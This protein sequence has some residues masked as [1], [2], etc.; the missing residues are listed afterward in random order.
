MKQCLIFVLLVLSLLLTSC[1]SKQDAERALKAAGFSNIHTDGFA[2]F[3]CGR[4]DFYRTKFSATNPKGDKVYGVV[5]S[6]LFF[7]NATIRF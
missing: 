5:C 2:W 6:G 1:T 4:D 3:A 7:K